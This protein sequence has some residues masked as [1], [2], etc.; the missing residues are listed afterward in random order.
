MWGGWDSK[1][2]PWCLMI[3]CLIMMSSGSMLGWFYVWLL[4]SPSTK[5]ET[6]LETDRHFGGIDDGETVT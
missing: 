6:L 4:L 3:L 2:W 5:G 1:V